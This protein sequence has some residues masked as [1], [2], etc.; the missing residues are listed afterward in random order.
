MRVKWDEVKPQYQLLQSESSNRV[1]YVLSRTSIDE[2]TLDFGKQQ[3]YI[4]SIS[5]PRSIS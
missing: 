2:K 1:S 4:F 3:E 5:N